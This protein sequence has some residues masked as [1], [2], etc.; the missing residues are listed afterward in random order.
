MDMDINQ[1]VRIEDPACTVPE[2]LRWTADFLDLASK[3]IS[4][5][6][7]AQGLEYPPTLHCAA[8]RD[9]RAWARYLDDRPSIAAD[10]ELASVL[11][12]VP[13]TDL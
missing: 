2:R 12:A 13:V 3:A 4:I 1:I 10:F 11:M 6:A 7:C 5:I 8:E 9:L